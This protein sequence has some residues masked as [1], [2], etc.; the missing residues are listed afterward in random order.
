[1]HHL[2][3]AHTPKENINKIEM[4]QRRAAC[5]VCNDYSP[6]SSVTEMLD[7]FG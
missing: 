6:Y 7:N 1:M 5:W 3:G 2:F 4:L